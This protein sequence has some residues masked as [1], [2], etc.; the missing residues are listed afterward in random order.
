[1]LYW[2]LGSQP[3]RA[4]RSILLAGG[5]EH[6][7]VHL[8]LFAGEHRQEQ[9]LKINPGGSLPFITFDGKP[10]YESAA[11]LRYLARKLPQLHQFYPPDDLEVCQMIDA[12]LDFNGTSLRPALIKQLFPRLAVTWL[13]TGK[14]SEND[15]AKIAEG[16]K[17]EEKVL[18]LME[19]ALE[20]RGHKFVGGDS[21]TIADHQLFAEFKDMDYLSR[22]WEQYP[23]ISK[24]HD[25]C[26]ESAGIKEVHDEWDKGVLPKVQQI[27]KDADAA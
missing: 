22:T 11:I 25:A 26:R 13:K 1:M 27:V 18:G 4:I 7:S 6:E 12:G 24:W 23:L 17:D 8:D 14:L 9:Y 2:N 10:M 15:K 3:S 16:I 21:I 19:K 20:L 5:V